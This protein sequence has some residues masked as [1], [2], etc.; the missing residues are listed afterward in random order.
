MHSVELTGVSI[1]FPVFGADDRS[2]KK[3]VARLALGG[4]VGFGGKFGHNPSVLALQNVHLAL[5]SGDRLG[6]IGPNGAGKTTLLRVMSGIYAPDAGIVS[7]RG[8]VSSLLELSLGLTPM[9]TGRENIQ[10]RGLVQGL[11]RR[12]IDRRMEEIAEF[13]GLGAFLDM[14]FR[15]YSSGMQARLAFAAATTSDA[16]ILI[17]DEWLAVGDADFQAKARERLLGLVNKASIYVLASHST[18]MIRNLC[19]KFIEVNHGRVGPIR[20]ISEIDMT[21]AV[22]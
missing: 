18:H 2:L 3:H 10:L 21:S 1:R 14:P 9:A 7:I 17:M 5:K 20:P 11:T 22:I 8:R 15:T 16:D 13:S 19:N 12:E 4:Q 6:V